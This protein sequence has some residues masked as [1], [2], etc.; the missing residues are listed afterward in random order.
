MELRALQPRRLGVGPERRD[1]GGLER[2]DEPGD[3]GCLGADHDQVAGLRGGCLDEP[4]DVT[5]ADL[6]TASIGGDP[7]VSRRAQQLRRALRARQSTDDRMLSPTAA[8]DEDPA[9][10]CLLRRPRAVA[11][12]SAATGI[13]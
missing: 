2:V 11:M 5:D 6:E 3:K 8:D 13:S 7:G 1:P 9:Q 10:R 4:R 12:G